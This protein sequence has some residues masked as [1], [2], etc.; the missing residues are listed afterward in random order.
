MSC[1]RTRG[2]SQRYQFDVA[3]VLKA[4]LADAVRKN[5]IPKNPAEI[6]TAP[7]DDDKEARFLTEDEVQRFLL[8]AKGFVDGAVL[9]RASSH[10]PAGR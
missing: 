1:W 6:A 2:L 3:N 7:K 10:G 5:L 9:R 8:A 4:G